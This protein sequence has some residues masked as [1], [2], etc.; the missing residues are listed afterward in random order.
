MPPR[1]SK[2][3]KLASTAKGLTEVRPLQ[4]AGRFRLRANKGLAR[5]YRALRRIATVRRRSPPLFFSRWPRHTGSSRSNIRVS[6]SSTCGTL[7]FA[8]GG[9]SGFSDLQFACA[10][11]RPHRFRLTLG[12]W[13]QLVSLRHSQPNAAHGGKLFLRKVPERQVHHRVVPFGATG[14]GV[15]E[16]A[17]SFNRTEI[18]APLFCG[19]RAYAC[20]TPSQRMRRHSWMNARIRNQRLR[21]LRSK[22][23]TQAAS[24]CFFS[25]SKAAM[26][27]PSSARKQFSPVR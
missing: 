10:G 2:T 18:Q 26:Q 13:R 25:E 23:F 22:P 20:S 9:V 11:R 6:P 8:I 5:I 15:A 19:A 24:A 3:E 21:V 1:T 7:E 17:I 12:I 27:P 14:P 16:S 4:F